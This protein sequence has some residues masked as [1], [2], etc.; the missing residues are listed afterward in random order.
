MEYTDGIT[1]AIVIVSVLGT[2]LG[3]YVTY[4]I[5]TKEGFR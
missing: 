3:L 5:Y 1:S 4:K 2:V